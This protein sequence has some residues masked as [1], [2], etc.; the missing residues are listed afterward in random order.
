M[1][2]IVL[3]GGVLVLVT[4]AQCFILAIKMTTT[5]K[6][7]LR[8][9]VGVT[10][11]AAIALLSVLPQ[12]PLA[13]QVLALSVLGINVAALWVVLSRWKRG[14]PAEHDTSPSPLSSQK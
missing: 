10:S 12:Q 9:L 6:K 4:V 8:V 11:F 5:A 14:M 13:V 7:Y 3:S 1:N 2:W